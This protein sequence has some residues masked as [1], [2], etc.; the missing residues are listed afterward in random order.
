M[1]MIE[2]KETTYLFNSFIYRDQCYDL[3]K[4]EL[5]NNYKFEKTRKKY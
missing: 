2:A 4:E 3:I 1:L 5:I